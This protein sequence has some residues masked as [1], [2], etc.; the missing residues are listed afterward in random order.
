MQIEAE[1]KK[2]K[3]TNL[4]PTNEITREKQQNHKTVLPEFMDLIIKQQ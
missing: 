3:A 2:R 1:T 4:S